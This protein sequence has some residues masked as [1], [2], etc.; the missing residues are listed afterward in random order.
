MIAYLKA[1]QS[2]CQYEENVNFPKTEERW[3]KKY[4]QIHRFW[5]RTD[6]AHYMCQQ[7]N[8]PRYLH[9]YYRDV[10]VWFPDEIGGT[11]LGMPKCNYLQVQQSC[12]ETR[13]PHAP[14]SP[15][16]CVA[17]RT[18]FHH[19]TTVLLQQ[20]PRCKASGRSQSQNTVVHVHGGPRASPPNA[21]RRDRF[22]VS[23]SVERSYGHG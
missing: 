9:A 10:F 20:V 4:L 19:V 12:P 18:L 21:T 1:L 16:C 22:H 14:S 13:L 6:A 2:R 23:C 3:L 15:T 7:L 11:V 5:I 8:I 17:S